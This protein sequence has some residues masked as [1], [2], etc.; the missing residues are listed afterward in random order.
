LVFSG[1]QLV[2]LGLMAELVTRTYFESQGR[3][4][5]TIRDTL[6]GSPAGS[7]AAQETRSSGEAPPPTAQEVDRP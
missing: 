7:P 6:C 2:T 5:Y 4:P 1:V 3:K